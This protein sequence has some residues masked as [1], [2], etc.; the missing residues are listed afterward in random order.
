MSADT[1]GKDS[2][3]LLHLTVGY[4]MVRF[5]VHHQIYLSQFDC[6][7]Y[8]VDEPAAVASMAQH[9]NYTLQFLES[10]SFRFTLVVSFVYT[11]VSMT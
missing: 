1:K 10:H 11:G 6:S 2:A 9:N 3:H 8:L 4:K 5:V 7:S